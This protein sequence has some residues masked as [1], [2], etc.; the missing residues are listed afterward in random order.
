M[1]KTVIINNREII[2]RECTI[3]GKEF[4]VR[5][6]HLPHFRTTKDLNI[7]PRN[8]KTCSKEC[9]KE[10]IKNLRRDSRMDKCKCG[11]WKYIYSKKCGKCHIKSKRGC[12][13]R[14][15]RKYERKNEK[16]K[17]N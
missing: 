1:E 4:Y 14:A 6:K 10:Y 13:G 5:K 9:S 15:I 16:M 12:V 7:R 3:C 8:A 11:N 17:N 2:V